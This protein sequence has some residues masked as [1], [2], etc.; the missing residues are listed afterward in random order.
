ME[1]LSIKRW[2]QINAHPL[3]FELFW[4]ALPEI[5]DAMNGKLRRI[6]PRALQSDALPIGIPDVPENHAWVVAFGAC[7]D[8]LDNAKPGS[9]SSCAHDKHC[10]PGR[11]HP[12]CAK[13]AKLADEFMLRYRA[14]WLAYDTG[15]LRK[16]ELPGAPEITLSPA[17]FFA[18]A[19]SPV[20]RDK[21]FRMKAFLANIEICVET[22]RRAEEEEKNQKQPQ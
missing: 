19:Y 1:K 13:A 14:I 15:Q 3:P 12:C 9:P 4:H 17:V 22:I 18:A 10:E 7:H 8:H 16:Y 20:R 6:H 5:T 11:L 21:T 2:Q